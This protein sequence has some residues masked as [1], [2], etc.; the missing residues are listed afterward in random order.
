MARGDGQEIDI[1]VPVED[2]VKSEKQKADEEKREEAARKGL[3]PFSD[4]KTADKDKPEDELSEDDLQLKNELEMLVERL[5]E[6]DH[7]L[8]RPALESLRTLI[9]TST[10]SMT[11]V[12]KPLK[13]LRPHYPEL[14]TLYDAW[15]VDNA[16]KALFAE[17]LSVLAMTY[18]D[19]GQRETLLYRLKANQV[20]SGSSED[21]G[22]WGHEYMRHLAAELGEEYDARSQKDESTEELLQLALQVVPFSLT[23]NAEAD[24]VDLLLELEAIDKLPQFVDKDTYARVCLYM[25]SCVNLL[26]PPDDAMFLRTAHEIYRKHER[27]TE[28]MTLALRLGDKDLIRSD[29]E[30]PKNFTMRKQL[31]FMLA[32]Q[33]IPIEWLQDDDNPLTDVQ[34]ID[35]M[36]NSHLSRHFVKF[37]K[38]LNVY[39]PK[40]LEDIYKT[41]LENSRTGLGTSVDSARGNLASTFVNAF[42]NAGF[43]NDK[44]MVDAPEGNSWIYK[45]KDHGMLSAAASLG[46]SLLWNTETGLDQIDKYTYS[47]EESIKA[48]AFLAYGIVHSGLR[49]ELD[50]AL[51]LLS[52]H[53]ES[54]SIPLKISAIVGLGLAYAGFCR[55]DIVPLLLPHIQ[56]E[57]TPMEVAAMSALALGFIFVGSCHGEITPTI[58]QSMMERD[59]AQLDDK[60]A[61]FMI[62]GLAL[63]FLGKQDESDATIETLKAI[64]HPIS[65]QAQV[66]VDMCSYAGTGNVLKVQKMLHYCTERSNPQ[67]SESTSGEGAESSSNAAGQGATANGDSADGDADKD[68]KSEADNDLFQTFAVI[69]IALVTMGEDV[70]AEMALRHMSHLMHYGE[71][72]IRRAVP[73]ALALLHPSDPAMPVLDTLSKYSHDSDLDVALNA[74]MAMGLVGAGTNNARLAQ[75][76]RQLAG[77]YHKEPDCLF[78]VRTAQGLVH[79]GKGTIGINP[80]HTDRQLMSRTAIAG[81]LSLLTSMTDARGF[82]LDRSHWMLFFLSSAMY[83]RFLITLDE[84]LEDLPTSVR[85][86]KAVDV[87]GQAGKPRTISGFQT[88]TTPVRVGTHERAELATEEYL[89]YPHVLEGFSILLKNPGYVKEEDL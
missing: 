10:S 87:V 76:L 70:G 63:L 15:K 46:M 66:L 67:E 62:L 48:G 12:P 55:E 88:H 30:A 7:N 38:E 4:K 1:T 16:D 23:H 8:Y 9:R 49:T 84:N 26:V 74:I 14:K 3:P 13:F 18:S 61:R 27:Y 42:V 29:F 36:Y 85:V 37:G 75:M 57:T 43:G 81:I 33:Q 24:A 41:H 56:D 47:S 58:L 80:Y 89:S 6:D 69:G 60:W 59:P 82:V 86:G 11:S 77:Y 5:K 44:L 78:M 20:T 32:R 39:E 2:P 79:M 52:E 28:A 72:A 31:A 73:L 53:I 71:P 45:N 65:K 25:V 17:I 34:L 64:D 68:K 83:P 19:N 21:P 51:A 22:L 35:I 54:K 40:S 50:E